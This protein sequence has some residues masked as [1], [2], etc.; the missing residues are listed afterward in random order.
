[1]TLSDEEIETLVSFGEGDRVECKESLTD[2]DKVC[3]AICAFANDLPRHQRPGIVVVGLDDHGVPTGS[4]V[5]DQLL[6]DLAHLRDNGNILP[7]PSMLV[8]KRRVRGAE[9]GVVTVEPS[10]SPPVRFRGRTWIR[11]GSRRAIATP[12]EETQ[13]VER[14]RQANLPFDAQPLAS[15]GIEDLD[16][17]GFMRELLPQLVAPDVLAAN[18]RSRPL[19][20]SS[21][22]FTDPDGSATPTGVL[23][24]GID[25]LAHIPGAYVQFLRFDGTGLADPIRSEHR[26]TGVLAQVLLELEEVLRVNIETA[27]VFAGQ[28]TETRRPSVPFEALQQ[29]VRNALMHR[30]YQGTNAPIRVSWF[31]DR[32]EIQSPGGPFGQVT[33]ENFG[34]PGMADY[35]NPTIAGVLHQLGY[36]QRFGVGIEIARERLAANGNSAPEFQVTPSTVNVVVRTVR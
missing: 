26:A 28:P 15:A 7:F 13:L 21:L 9:V 22:R 18:R 36:V 34:T 11:V 30:S 12:E 33:V 1:M 20:L 5:T 24:A 2:R 14:R 17:D 3:E 29:L 25:P 16:V 31:D 27:V 8:E 10:A 19:Q 6:Q 32:V 35:R 4:P 23:F